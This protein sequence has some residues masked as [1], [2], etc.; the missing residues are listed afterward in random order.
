MSAETL[1]YSN[2]PVAPFSVHISSLAFTVQDNVAKLIRT[3]ETP[4]ESLAAMNTLLS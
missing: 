1:N 2:I 3:G 4:Q